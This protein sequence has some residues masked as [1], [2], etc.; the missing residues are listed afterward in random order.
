MPLRDRCLK[1][2]DIAAGAPRRYCSLRSLEDEGFPQ[3]RRLPVCLRIVLE[4]LLRNCDGERVTEEHV[5][6][7]AAWEPNGA[8]TKEIPFV[9]GRIVLQD[10]AGIPALCDL[11]AL[12]SAAA[13][14]GRDVSM[15][16]PRV[17][18]DM[19]IDHAIDVDFHGSSDALV[20]NAALEMARNEE[21]FLF[22][23]WAM[24][25]FEGVRLIP[26]GFGILHQVNLEFL[27]RGLMCDGEYVFLDTLVGTD[28]H[29]CM[30]AGLG[31]VGWGVGGIE[32]QAAMLGQPV[33]FVTPDVVAV[34][35]RGSLAPGVTSTDLVLHVTQ[36][37]RKAKVVGQFLEF[38]GDGVAHLSVPDRATV[39]N[40]APEYGAT[41]AFFPFDA[42]TARYLLE[43]GRAP[44]DVR[45]LE[46]YLELQ[47]CMG[48]ASQAEVEY[49]RRIRIDLADVVPALAGPKRPQDLVP[50]TRMKTRFH[51][52]LHAP[53]EEGGYAR[54][55]GAF[56]TMEAPASPYR[57]CDGDVL[58]AAITSCTN[59]SNPSVMLAAGLLAKAAVA[60]GLATR[61][62][63]KTSLAPGSLVVGRY[64]EAAG[65]QAPLDSLGFNVVGY[66]C[67]T[68]VGNAGPLLAEVEAALKGSDTIACA[69]LSGNRNFEARI[70]P[71]LRASYL[72]S[73]PLVVAYALAGTVDIDFATQPL[74]LDTTG[75]PVFLADLWP[76]TATVSAAVASAARPAF[77]RSVY[78][79]A[80]GQGNAM[81][82][83]LPAPTG[84]LYA[85]DEASTFFLE[86]PFLKD[87]H[88]RRTSLVDIE[89]AHA[90]AILGDSVTT[91]HISPIASISAQSD[92]G[93]YLQ[94]CGVVPSAFG[95]FGARRTNHEVMTRGGFGNLHLRNRM[96][97]GEE[98][99][100][101]TCQPGGQRLSIFD[102]AQRY[103]ERGTPLLV[104]AGEE[105]GT[106]SARDWAAKATRLLGVRAVVAASFERIH[107]SNLAGM[108]VLPCQL[109]A[110]IS[111]SSLELDG[112]ETF[113][114]VG[115]GDGVS[116]GQ[117]LTLTIT[118]VDGSQRSV[119]LVL[120]LDTPLEIECAR[121][122]G[123]LPYVLD[124]LV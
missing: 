13:R 37:L 23:K 79:D 81:W 114:I 4:S 11:A 65:L 99:P 121:R 46:R 90:L 112:T 66:G 117:P 70:H 6:N 97:G 2:F 39:A 124:Q 102:A 96:V 29:T 108:G 32:A 24:Q 111:V 15:V 62:W 53:V 118:R 41:L 34:E 61:P 109:P 18:V 123:L 115:L 119:P 16:R 14:Q 54:A 42:Q 104:F 51:D 92:A 52:V 28:S 80:L 78:A 60:R 74:G 59:T 10:V 3:L 25:A 86:P 58:I 57:P 33:C 49:T 89:G 105:Y 106:G 116:P 55:K 36:L 21:R 82:D 77:Y 27:A 45:E 67:T 120:R 95:S 107:R 110:D 76:S 84:E 1:T 38:V 5:R 73:P 71:S 31:V 72:A 9:V 93:R 30:V 43:T 12:R 17:P 7:L 101:T 68:C 20:R 122:G 40:M 69:V 85:W 94:A 48:G 83:A 88:L 50:L 22:V 8:R 87:D 63:V 64:L 103:R 44:D 75:A 113:A 91:D 98:G 47:H 56:R 26:S 19:V 35:L 100:W